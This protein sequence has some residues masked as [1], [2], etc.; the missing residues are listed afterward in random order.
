MR[1]IKFR[2]RDGDDWYYGS[3][4]VDSV[5]RTA[6]AEKK[7]WWIKPVNAETVGQYTGL[8]DSN[9]K[10]IYEG[11]ILE[12]VHILSWDDVDEKSV[13][14]VEFKY[15]SFE[16]VPSDA[17]VMSLFDLDCNRKQFPFTVIGN[18][19]DNPELLEA[20]A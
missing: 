10:E 17:S 19:H 1:E 8:N 18:I 3:L 15:Y 20:H 4:Y 13:G 2:G 16:V 9:G 5:G 6:I 14:V 7:N 11:D 12:F